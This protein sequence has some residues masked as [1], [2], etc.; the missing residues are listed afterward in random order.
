MRQPLAVSV[1]RRL[2]S[3]TLPVG[4]ITPLTLPSEKQDRCR[5]APGRG[6]D[7]GLL[8]F[9]VETVIQRAVDDGVEPVFVPAQI[10]G[11][12]DV[13]IHARR[14]G[15][16][17]K[18]ACGPPRSRQGSRQARSPSAHATPDRWS[19]RR[20]RSRPKTRP[21][22]RV[23]SIG[24]APDGRPR[25]RALEGGLAAVELVEGFG[26]RAEGRRSARACLR[27][28]AAV[29]TRRRRRASRR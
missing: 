5:R 1:S 26:T 25:G 28:S 23:P 16:R 9:V 12:G 22:L 11:V 19:C 14:A 24:A 15:S 6:G 17:V 20:G 8:P 27:G 18:D 3:G 21:A 2:D 7:V 13:A 10:G 4:A 29:V